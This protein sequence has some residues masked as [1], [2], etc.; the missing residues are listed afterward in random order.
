MKPLVHNSLSHW[1]YLVIAL[2]LLTTRDVAQADD[3]T[4]AELDRYEHV[5]LF[6]YRGCHTD[7]LR[8][9]DWQ[10]Q[11][12]A[13][14]WNEY[15]DQCISSAR[16]ELENAHTSAAASVTRYLAR[17]ALSK[18]HEANLILLKTLR[19]EPNESVA[20][21]NQRLNCLDPCQPN[22]GS[23]GKRVHPATF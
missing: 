14:R 8:A 2:A 5:A 19:P 9:R 18:Y 15:L 21:H 22:C 16:V 3:R 11:A 12:N 23:V 1:H 13:I 20:E 6:S 17:A 4:Q 10:G 7:L